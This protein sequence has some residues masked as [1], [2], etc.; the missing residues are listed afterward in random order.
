MIH[1]RCVL[2]AALWM[3][4]I[5]QVHAATLVDVGPLQ[6]IAGQP[7]V[8][9]FDLDDADY[10]VG[11]NTYRYDSRIV[12]FIALADTPHPPQGKRRESYRIGGFPPGRYSLEIY[13]DGPTAKLIFS[14]DVV[15]SSP[16]VVPTLSVWAVVVV[17]VGILGIGIARR[18]A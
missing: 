2:L 15:V 11:L 5:L 8:A 7:I 17:A 1:W 14:S 4:E 3:M 16:A 6:P 12:A 10:V 9:T 13:G 18:R